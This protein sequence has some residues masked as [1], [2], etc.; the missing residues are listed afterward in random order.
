MNWFT[1]PFTVFQYRNFTFVWSSTTLV[2]IGTQMEAVVLGWYILAVTESPVLVG[3]I[4][5]ARMSLNVFAL[6]AGA[7]ADRVPRNKLLAVVE[8]T[9]A[10]LA[11]LMLGLIVTGILQM[12]HIFFIAVITGM[13]RVFQ[14]PSAQSLVADTLPQDR[15]PNG[16]AFNTLGRNI[17]MVAGPLVGGIL[18]QKMGPQG[19][20]VAIAILYFVSGWFAWVI[21]SRQNS[22]KVN[23]EP[24]IKDVISGVK[25]VKGEQVLWATLVVALIIE[26]AGWTF[27]TTLVPIY[28]WS[29]LNTDAAGLGLL[30]FA[31]GCGSVLG[32]V[33]W[34]F[35]PNLSHVGKLMFAA[36]I[37]WHCSI[38]IFSTTSSF[39]LSMCILIA[40]GAGFGSTQVFMLSALLGTAM[41]EYR[42]RVMSLRS[43]A[44]YAFALGSI[45]TGAMAGIWGAQLAAIITG[46]LGLI[47]IILL[48]IVAPKL[49]SL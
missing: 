40:V 25:Y 13:V 44:I 46:L 31:F 24:V 43:M 9:M 15:I 7:V 28:A 34:A 49:R 47:F 8:F 36:V 37:F 16:A 19:A 26:S 11:I 21:T 10:F 38:L 18:Y 33:G 1:Y 32:S 35:I 20:F 12:W 5:A 42:G 48:I 27:H 23:S 4:S 45:F 14:I 6:F 22:L 39:Y 2:G 30:L 29:V 3:L 17:A 41:A